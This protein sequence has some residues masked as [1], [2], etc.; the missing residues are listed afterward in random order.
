MAVACLTTLGCH[1][2]SSVVLSS[3]FCVSEPACLL[4]IGLIAIFPQ[5]KFSPK[6]QQIVRDYYG[7]GLRLVGF[8]IYL[9]FFFQARFKRSKNW[10][11]SHSC[12][13]RVWNPSPFVWHSSAISGSLSCRSSFVLSSGFFHFFVANCATV[14]RAIGSL[15]RKRNASDLI[16]SEERSTPL[17]L[18]SSLLLL[19]AA[20]S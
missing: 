2:L 17:S 19:L 11:G 12:V 15:D 1:C 10:W 9:F 13:G 20:S 5:L 16:W 8:Y 4:C 18:F 6:S 7:Y 3:V 14:A